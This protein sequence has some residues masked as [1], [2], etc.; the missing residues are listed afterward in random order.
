MSLLGAICLL[1]LVQQ[2]RTFQTDGQRKLEQWL[3]LQYLEFQV[4]DVLCKLSTYT[5][6]FILNL[7][8]VLRSDLQK[9]NHSYIRGIWEVPPKEQIL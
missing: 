8:G 7:F 6:V 9:L 1:Q 4:G 3:G 5:R 2:I